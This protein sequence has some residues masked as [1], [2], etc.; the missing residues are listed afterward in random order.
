VC[1][2]YKGDIP[3]K[4]QTLRFSLLIVLILCFLIPSI[5][6]HA[7]G[8]VVDSLLDTIGIDGICTLREAIQ[9]ANNDAITN[10]DCVAGSGTDTITFSVSG[11]IT[12]DS[13]LP[14][15]MDADGLTIDGTGQTVTI[16]GNNAVRVFYAGNTLTLNHL[17]IANG[18]ST[19]GVVGGGIYHCCNGTLTIMDSTFSGN[20]VDW[21]GAGGGIYNTGGPLTIMNSIFSGNNAT[22]SGGGIYNYYSTLTI[23]NSTFSGNSA[24]SGAWGSGGGGISNSGG[25]LTITNSTFS[26]NSASFSGGGGIYNYSNTLTITNSSFSGNSA[27]AGGG[28][29][30]YYDTLII[31]NSTFSDNS[32]TGTGGGIFNIGTLIVTNSSL[33]GNSASSGGG[34]RNLNLQGGVATLRNTVVA[35]SASGG[36]CNGTITNEGNNIDDGTTCGWGSASGS[37]SST[38][39]LLGT[40]T[41]NGGPT[42]TFAL[43]AGSPAIDAGDDAT[44]SAAPVNGLDQRGVTRPQGAHCDIGAFELVEFSLSGN[45]GVAAATLSYTDGTPRTATA[46]SDGNY[47][48]FVSNNWTGTVTPSLPGYTFSPANIEYENVQSDQTDQN[49]TATAFTYT[50]SGNAG[51]AGATLSF[52]DGGAHTVTADSLGNY[53]LV[54]SYNWS[55]M[56][57]PSLS[58]YSF[59]PVNRTYVN[60]LEDQTD[61]NYEAI[62]LPGELVKY[63][64]TNGA[65]DQLLYATLNWGAALNAT[66]YEYCYDT[67]ND[68]LCGVSWINTGTTTW[69]SLSDLKP[70]TNYYWQVRAVNSTGVTYADGGTW[71]SFKTAPLTASFQSNGVYDGW[72][73][74][75]AAHSGKGGSLNSTSPVLLVGDDALN[76]QYR[77]ILS[78][79]T[80]SLPDTAV[81]T[82]VILQ[83]LQQPFVTLMYPSLVGGNPFAALGNLT[84]DIRK[85]S[86]GSSI[87]LEIGDFQAA[88]N[89]AGAGTFGATPISDWYTA[90]LVAGSLKYINMV[91]LTQFRL[92]FSTDSNNNS[93]IENVQIYRGSAYTAPKPPVLIVKYYVP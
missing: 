76:R 41:D 89:K 21:A 37:M 79:D 3:M 18:Y 43:L 11:M 81:V 16:S 92:R 53:S 7:A 85:G 36:N 39:P 15:I 83:V 65:T 46:D 78:F 88:A 48:L 54:V 32:A 31:T 6:A 52:D 20:R 1:F 44:C 71:W 25:P 51:V 12:L 64:P 19:G 68:N 55:G 66:S 10:T 67:T 14:V 17:T 87:A 26:S 29:W 93:A 72:V 5:R 33:S 22:D 30:N 2:I 75:S 63:L 23:T 73:L 13:E 28:I 27:S 84:V 62:P 70:Y 91:G 8:L 34:I 61:Q 60:V 50:I 47:S 74:E 69:K 90:T 56:V 80:S 49:Y 24:T 86:F 9:N 82:Q 59:S 77:A 38:D 58:G 57:T 42:Q 45:A 35:N 4:T 40:L